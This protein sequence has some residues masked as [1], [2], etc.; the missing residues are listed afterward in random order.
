MAM[1]RPLL[2]QSLSRSRHHTLRRLAP[3]RT[4]A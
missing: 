3:P 4:A 2:R 1:L